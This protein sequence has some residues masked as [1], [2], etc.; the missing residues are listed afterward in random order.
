MRNKFKVL[1]GDELVEVES[2]VDGDPLAFVFKTIA[3]PYVGQIS[4][5]KVLSGTIK[6]ESTLT[7]TRTGSDE[8]LAKI[9]ALA[10][11]E[12]ELVNELA[13]GD[14]GAVT[15]LNNTATGDTLAP[16]GKPVHVPAIDRPEPVLAI[17]I[18]PSTTRGRK[19]SLPTPCVGCR[20]RMLR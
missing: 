15:K 6:A 7:N 12:S 19:T 18:K 1:A 13:A 11:K 16:K 20:R 9:A 8:R 17:A 4:M 10:G 14:I 5:F 2:S 3:D